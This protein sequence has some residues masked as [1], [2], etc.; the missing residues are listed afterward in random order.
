MVVAV[1][2]KNYSL[3]NACEDSAQWTG[4]NAAD[5]TAFFKRG[6]QCIGFELWASGNLDIYITGSW[7]LSGTKH[8]R[9]WMM[10]TVLNELNT[11]ANGGVQFYI[12]DGTST[13]Y[14]YVSGKTTYPGGWYNLVIDLSRDVDNGTK[15]TMTSITTIGLRFNL[16]TGAK[17]VQ[18]LWIDHIYTGDGLIAYGDDGGSAFD[19]D[20]ILTADED[21][22]NGWGMIRKMG[23]VF[24]TVGSFTLGDTGANTCDFQPMSDIIIFEDR[25]VNSSLY[26]IDA[27]AGTG[28]TSVKFGDKSGSSGISGCVIKSNAIGTAFKLTATDPDIDAFGLY[29]TTFDTHGVIDLQPYDAAF[30]VLN[31]N[32]V[33]GQGQIQPNTMTF[34]NNNM[35]SNVDT[36]GAVL[37]E[38]T[39]HNMEYNNYINN[40]RATEFA[41]ANTYGVTGDQF[42][43]NTYDVHFSA[44][45]GDLIINCGGS[46]KANPSS[47]END[48][49]G[50]VTINNTVN[51]TIYVK[52]ASDESNITDALVF[53]KASSA[54]GDYPYQENVTIVSSAGTAT[55]TH[56][57]H[58][59][60]TDEYV[61]IAGANEQE[62]NGVHQI[63]VTGVD[64]YTYTVSG[65][66]ASPA[67]GTITS[68]FV[69]VFELT[70][71]G[72]ASSVMRYKTS[73]QPF[74]GVV[75]RSS[76]TPLYRQGIL[77]GTVENAD[78]STTVYLVDDE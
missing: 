14:Y 38:S 62:Y 75:R 57:T 20:D 40:S 45:T 11:D 49:T 71:A 18:S 5:V 24:Y 43:G 56:A 35:V 60:Q 13:G 21:T 78:Y 48:S 76:T 72:V 36:E 51:V 8:L 26:A 52:D 2:G 67:T 64:T 65:T 3:I 46:P 7:D 19:F 74:T 63:T 69:I 10:T 23:G 55:V 47:V 29:G 61:Q 4:G 22:T 32:F 44:A 25:K 41:V 33:S 39:S 73:D 37:F 9:C 28:T 50:T 58:G 54:A 1:T 6:T 30:E 34:K 31:C 17:K 42:S 53:L 27:V 59:L 77:S 12:S 68:T 70:V 66:A 15:P 16:T